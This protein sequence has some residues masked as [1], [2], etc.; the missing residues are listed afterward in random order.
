MVAFSSTLARPRYRSRASA[1]SVPFV[2]ATLQLASLGTTSV[3]ANVSLQRSLAGRIPNIAFS[4]IAAPPSTQRARV[5]DR[6][7]IGNANPQSF[8]NP[9]NLEAFGKDIGERISNPFEQSRKV[10][11]GEFENPNLSITAPKPTVST[12]QSITLPAALGI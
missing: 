4:N 2:R 3:S 10:G 1:G 8:G 9:A 5:S 12:A 6:L 11:I 7:N